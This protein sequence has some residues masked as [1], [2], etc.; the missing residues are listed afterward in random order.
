MNLPKK[1]KQGIVMQ[2]QQQTEA[3]AALRL[4][5]QIEGV[6]L[7]EPRFRVIVGGWNGGMSVLWALESSED[8]STA[9]VITQGKK[10]WEKQLGCSLPSHFQM[11]ASFSH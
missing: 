9:G 3:P 10:K 11:P 6:I 4:E 8:A 5:E 1:N 2:H 7:P